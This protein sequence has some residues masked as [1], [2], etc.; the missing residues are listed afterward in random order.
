MKWRRISR[1]TKPLSRNFS[2]IFIF[3]NFPPQ[4]QI[5][6]KTYN[7]LQDNGWWIS[8]KKIQVDILKNGWDMTENLSKTGTFLVISGLYRD[9]PIFFADF[10][11][12]KSV[13][14][15]FFASFAKIWPKNQGCGVDQISATSTPTPTHISLFFHM[16][17]SSVLKQWYLL[18][19][20]FDAK[21]CW[22]TR[23]QNSVKV[24]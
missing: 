14:G 10:A 22:Q 1:A 2:F 23:Q 24:C 16:S 6:H 19:N 11:V 3:Q 17:K 21:Y 20:V 5:F 4:N 8:V 18:C 9:F 13:Y 7:M 15:S 12:S